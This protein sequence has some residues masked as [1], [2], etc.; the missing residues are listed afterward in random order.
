MSAVAVATGSGVVDPDEGLLLRALE[1]EGVE[2]EVRR[3]DDP[4]ARWATYDL[5][6]IRSTWDYVNRLDEF[7]AWTK[8]VPRLAN[9]WGAVRY[10]ID[11][12]YLSQLAE[13]GVATVPTDVVAVGETFAPPDVDFVVKPCVGAGAIDATRYRASD[14]AAR[15]HVGDLHARGRDVLVQPYVASV[16]HVGERDVVFIDGSLSHVMT[17]GALLN[18]PAPER[19]ALYRREQMSRAPLDDE[20]VDAAR[21]ALAATGFTNLLYARVDLVNDG[22]RWVVMEVELVEPSLFLSFEEGSARRLARAIAERASR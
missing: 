4:S 9:P 20:V 22:G 5:V 16:D 12:R 13:R 1:R 7:L 19:T 10:S 18:A 17:K 8:S 15:A 2:A 11:K 3:W 21:A 14:P 6:V